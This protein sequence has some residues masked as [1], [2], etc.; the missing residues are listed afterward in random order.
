[1][2]VVGGNAKRGHLTLWVVQPT[3]AGRPV[4]L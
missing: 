3:V 2:D 1:V 4:A